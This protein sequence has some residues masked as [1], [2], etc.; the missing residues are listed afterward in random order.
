MS[1]SHHSVVSCQHLEMESAAKA[2]VSNRVPAAVA[3][4]SL[5]LFVL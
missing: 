2:F 4:G 1:L 3:V 5:Q